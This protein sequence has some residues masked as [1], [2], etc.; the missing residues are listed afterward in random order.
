[1]VI[2]IISWR[3]LL[4]FSPWI[5][6]WVIY[7]YYANYLLNHAPIRAIRSMNLAE[8]CCGKNLWVSDLNVLRSI[9]WEHFFRWLQKEIE[10]KK[11]CLH[12][13]G[14]IEGLKI[15]LLF[16]PIKKETIIGRNVI[17]YETYVGFMFFNYLDKC[18]VI[19][20]MLFNMIDWLSLVFMF[21]PISQLC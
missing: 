20:L 11:S 12:H 15:L 8:L 5:K 7:L 21:Q 4:F 16:D 18:R 1:M 17:L 14:I 9:S 6:K 13:D 3:I 2:L 19:P 10:C